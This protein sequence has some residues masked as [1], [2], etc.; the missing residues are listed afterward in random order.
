MAEA[1]SIE[2]EIENTESQKDA[3]TT[4]ENKNQYQYE[5]LVSDLKIMIERPDPSFSFE[6]RIK[7]IPDHLRKVNEQAYTPTIISIGLF[8]YYNKNLRTMEKFKV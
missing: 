8:H 3:N 4:N 2:I 5:R 7:R 6:C 1:V